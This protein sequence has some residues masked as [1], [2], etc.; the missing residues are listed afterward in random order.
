MKTFKQLKEQLDI[1]AIGQT[2][3]RDLMPQL[4]SAFL[5]YLKKKNISYTKENVNTSDLKST[6]SEFDTMKILNLMSSDNN[7][8]IFVSNDDY[9]LDGHHRWIADHNTDGKTEAYVID[10]PI[11]ELYR[12]A[13]EYESILKEDVTH[14]DF[15]PMMD[16]F[17]SF[18]S[19]KLF[20]FQ[21]Q[22]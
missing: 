11:L 19:D 1:P 12:I 6:Q 16:S 20:A 4:D 9:V 7:D 10:L 3:S 8:T 2:F 17:V 14:K 13:K 18:A 22:H 15:G 21:S 5:K